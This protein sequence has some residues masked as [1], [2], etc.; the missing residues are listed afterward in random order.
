[1]V[2][3]FSIGY[4]IRTRRSIGDGCTAL[5]SSNIYLFIF[6][7]FMV[8]WFGLF[9]SASAVE[10]IDERSNA[11]FVSIKCMSIHLHTNAHLYSRMRLSTCV[12][13]IYVRCIDSCLSCMHTY[14]IRYVCAIEELRL[15][16]FGFFF[17]SSV[18]FDVVLSQLWCALW[19]WY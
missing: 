5:F 11:M 15:Y 13:S 10:W 4:I 8:I 9:P 3:E 12:T 17:L 18:F 7:K 16:A 1:M 2:F 6:M 14:S 19:E